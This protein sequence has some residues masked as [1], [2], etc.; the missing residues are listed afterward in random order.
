MDLD[1]LQVLG[2]VKGKDEFVTGW[3]FVEDAPMTCVCTEPDAETYQYKNKKY[4][5]YSTNKLDWGL[6]AIDRH[7]VYR[8]SIEFVDEKMNALMVTRDLM[9]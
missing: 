7:E 6:N 3:L 1:K 8:D 5:I 4:Y 9:G 2:K